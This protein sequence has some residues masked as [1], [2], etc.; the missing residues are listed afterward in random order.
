MRAEG[1]IFKRTSV[2]DL[3]EK[4][5]IRYYN[6][7]RNA[8]GDLVK[9]GEEIRCMVWAK[10]LTLTGKIADS[11]PEKVNTVTYRITIRYRTDVLPDDFVIWRGKRFRI[12]TP[13]IDL[14][15]RHIWT[16]FDCVEVIQDGKAAH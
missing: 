11:T 1:T 2:D 4:I 6:F 12:I 5:S 3:S 10:V 8:R 16:Q 13:P 7:T 9:G 15:V 14:E